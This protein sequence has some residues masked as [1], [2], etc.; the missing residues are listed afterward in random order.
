MAPLF[1][2][3][4]LLFDRAPESSRGSDRLAQ[5]GVR[6]LKF[7]DLDWARSTAKAPFF[8]SAAHEGSGW[9]M[10]GMT[11]VDGAG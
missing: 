10:I 9:G 4:T 11:V 6:P 7:H 5:A 1:E 3:T 2:A 8:E